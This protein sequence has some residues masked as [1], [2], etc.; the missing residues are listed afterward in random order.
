MRDLADAMMNSIS[1]DRI[2]REQSDV[3]ELLDLEDPSMIKFI[4]SSLQEIGT[5]INIESMD[6]PINTHIVSFRSNSAVLTPE[7]IQ[8]EV[9][10]SL[11]E[12]ELFSCCRETKTKNTKI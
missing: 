7:E 9:V 3:G 10:K 5:S 6:L 4:G 2:I 11:P 8:Q 1:F 12:K